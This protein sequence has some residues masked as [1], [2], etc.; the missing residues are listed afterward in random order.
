MSNPF[1]K[2][3]QHFFG[4]PEFSLTLY[5]KSGNRIEIDRISEYEFR[6]EG[7]RIVGIRLVQSLKAKNRLLVKT[8][9]LDQIEAVTRS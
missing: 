3:W 1:V 6:S 7:D 5:M 8:I 4:T 2:L 9:A